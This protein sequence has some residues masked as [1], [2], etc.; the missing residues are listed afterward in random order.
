[1]R[2]I[3]TFNV[4]PALPQRL[5]A[6]RALAYNLHWDGTLKRQICSAAL[7]AD[8]W[9]SSRFNPVLMLGTHQPGPAAGRW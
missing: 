6:L 7:D 4:T 3:R 8:L 5:E 9:E 1:M 2:P